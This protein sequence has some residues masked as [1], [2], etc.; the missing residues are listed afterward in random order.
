MIEALSRLNAF[1]NPENC[2]SYVGFLAGILADNPSTAETLIAESLKVRSADR[3]LVLRAIAYSGLPNWKSLLRQYADRVPARRAMIDKYIG[4]KLP[5]LAQLSIT[6]SPSAWQKFIG[7]F[8]LGETE[9]KVQ[10]EPSPD[11]LDTLWGYY[12]GTGSYGP[13][14]RL[15][16]LLPWS[17]DRNDAARLTIGSM[18][19]YTLARNASHD[20]ALLAMLVSSSK[21]PNAAKDTVKILNEIIEAAQTVDTAAIRDQALAAIDELKRKGPAYKRAV[22]WWG[23]MGESTIAAGCLAAAVTGQ[24]AL[25]LPCVIGGATSSA[26]MN[27]WTNQP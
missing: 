13:V 17:N 1:D 9:H 5:T 20:Q 21:A 25:G 16:A 6:R 27:F 8:R 2:G 3:W 11:V 14:M 12:F 22:S 4:G 24:V 10:L 7:H 19:K 18:T 15:I 23:Y 26:A